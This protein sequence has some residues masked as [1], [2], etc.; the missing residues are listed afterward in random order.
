MHLLRA[1]LSCGDALWGT[2]VGVVM[3]H[4]L[5]API[6]FGDALWGTF[7]APL[8]APLSGDALWGTYVCVVI[9]HLLRAPSFGDALGHLCDNVCVVCTVCLFSLA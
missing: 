3:M 8:R 4:L 1:P 2:Y 6:F 7:I 5:R 9:M